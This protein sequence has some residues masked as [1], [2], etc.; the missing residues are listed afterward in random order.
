MAASMTFLERNFKHAI[1]EPTLAPC[2]GGAGPRHRYN[3]IEGFIDDN[4]E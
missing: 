4:A 2:A 1:R 3:Y